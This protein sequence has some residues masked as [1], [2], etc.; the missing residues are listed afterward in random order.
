MQDFSSTK[1]LQDQQRHKQ[2]KKEELKNQ[3]PDEL[4]T[5]TASM[6]NQAPDFKV[7]KKL[8]LMQFLFFRAKNLRVE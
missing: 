8:S 6:K 4:T 1:K 3:A 7:R 2:K 5:G